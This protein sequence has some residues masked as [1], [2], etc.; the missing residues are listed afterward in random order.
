MSPKHPSP[1]AASPGLSVGDI[2]YI[3]FRHKWKIVSISGIGIA[4]ALIL[5]FFWPRPYQSEAKLFIRYVV[6][7]RGPTISQVGAN[8]SRVKSPDERGEN[9][10]NT[11]LEI[12]TSLDLAYEVATNLPPEI[13]AKLS[14]TSKPYEAAAMISR[15]LIPEAPKNSDVIRLSFQNSDPSTAQ[16]VLSKVIETYFARHAKIHHAVGVYD[17]VFTEEKDK[18]RK[19]L[20]DTEE[21]LRQA[22]T[23]AQIIS[24][25]EDKK[26]YTEQMGRLQQQIFDTQADLA[27]RRSALAEFTK[28]LRPASTDTNIGGT[29][30]VAAADHDTKS[31]SLAVAAGTPTPPEKI[32]QYKRISDLLPKLGTQ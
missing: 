8:D 32:S 19:D 11:E 24:L 17:S 12:L 16:V 20:A 9:I 14:A 21:L 2:Y 18:L 28:T 1:A 27:E 5:P 13:L 10:I 22:K 29:N 30:S 31:N 4:A 25:Q 7:N 3:L 26:L 15:G 6:E 23:N